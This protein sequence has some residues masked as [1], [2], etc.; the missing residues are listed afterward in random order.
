[1]IT[2]LQWERH[3]NEPF[4]IF[5]ELPG[6]RPAGRVETELVKPPLPQWRGNT[7]GHRF[8]AF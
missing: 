6:L 1:M 4:K 3:S 7:V 2:V 8:A 5:N